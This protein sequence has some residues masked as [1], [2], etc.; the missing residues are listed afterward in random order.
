[1]LGA[2][3]AS[4]VSVSTCPE[5]SPEIPTAQSLKALPTLVALADR[6]I[7]VAL[8][9]RPLSDREPVSPLHPTRAAPSL[10]P[11]PDTADAHLS[12]Y[13]H[14]QAEAVCLTTQKTCEQPADHINTNYIA[15][16]QTRT[17]AGTSRIQAAFDAESNKEAIAIA[18]ARFDEL[19]CNLNIIYTNWHHPYSGGGIRGDSIWSDLS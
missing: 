4:C 18:K 5:T 1:M 13:R 9:Y 17:T 2:L 15:I 6:D 14:R 12:L 16:G 19:D 8:G 11:S 3:W 10:C 7:L